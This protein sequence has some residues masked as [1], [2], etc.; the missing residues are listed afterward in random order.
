[1]KS[2]ANAMRAS[3]RSGAQRHSTM[4]PPLSAARP[5]QTVPLDARAIS[6]RE[7]QRRGMVASSASAYV[8]TNTLANAIARRSSRARAT[9]GA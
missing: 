5:F 9:R 2:T 6:S 7:H 8:T 3:E 1:V 4:L